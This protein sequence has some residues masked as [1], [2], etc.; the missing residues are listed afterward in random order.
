MKKAP[1]NWVTK[2]AASRG[3]K[4]TLGSL[5]EAVDDPPGLTEVKVC[6]RRTKTMPWLQYKQPKD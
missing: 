6:V 4:G 5:C 1:T 2:H 3:R